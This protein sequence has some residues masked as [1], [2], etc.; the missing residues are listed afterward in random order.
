MKALLVF[1]FVSY[2]IY[3]FGF[4]LLLLFFAGLFFSFW[5]ILEYLVVQKHKSGLYF[6][7]Y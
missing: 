2:C 1:Y 6:T 7:F 5:F 3:V 4:K